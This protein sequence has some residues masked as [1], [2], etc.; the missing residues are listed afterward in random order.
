MASLVQHIEFTDKLV[1]QKERK[2]EI[3][4]KEGIMKDTGAHAGYTVLWDRVMKVVWTGVHM[5][6][7]PAAPPFHVMTVLFGTR[8][9]RVLCMWVAVL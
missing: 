7:Y 6:Y 3:L 2:K 5:C 4:Y 9:V 8:V 1:Y